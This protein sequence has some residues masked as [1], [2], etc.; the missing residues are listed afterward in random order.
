MKIIVDE[1]TDG[2]IIR[3]HG[4]IDILTSAELRS[5]L[6]DLTKKKVMNISVDLE[7][8]TY[9][10]SSGLATLLE[11]L[12]NLKEY[13]GKMKLLNVPDRILKVLSLMKLDII[14]DIQK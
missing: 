12:K 2:K 11:G 1:M 4:K 9:I 8:V 5:M 3:P 10:D 6:N 13:D 14:F 7:Q